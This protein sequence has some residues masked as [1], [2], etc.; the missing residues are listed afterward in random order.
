[1]KST[2]RKRLIR[3][4]TKIRAKIHGTAK[5]PRLAV[6]RSV[7]HIQAQ[8]IDDENGKTI[9]G[10]SD[11]SLKTKGTKKERAFKVGAELA[12]KAIEKGIEE[13]VFDRGGYTYHGRVEAVAEG[14]RKSGLRF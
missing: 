9:I 11:I 6:A 3:R 13:A 10:I 8:L 12:K 7:A 2:P 4:H 5:R 14:A 1:M